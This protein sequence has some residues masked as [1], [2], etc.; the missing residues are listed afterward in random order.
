M[1]NPSRHTGFVAGWLVALG[2]A[3]CSGTPDTVCTSNSAAGATGTDSCTGGAASTGGA[4]ATGGVSATGGLAATGGSSL[5]TGGTESTGGLAST[6]G[7]LATGG[8]EATG[9]LTATG[10][11]EPTGGTPATG[12]AEPTGGTPATGGAEATGGSEATGGT[13]ATGG[14]PGTG[15][16][17]PTGGMPATGGAEPT[18]GM[19]ATGGA[20]TGGDVAT[21]G[22]EA[23]GGSPATG[24][25]AATGGDMG[26]GGSSSIGPFCT[27]GSYAFCEDFEDSNAVGWSRY[28]Q[29]TNAAITTYVVGSE[30]GYDGATTW[31]FQQ[32]ATSFA[33]HHYEVADSFGKGPWTD[34]TVTAWVKP[35]TAVAQDNT[36]FGIC[37]RMS[38]TN[39]TALSGY[40]L[41]LQVDGTTGAGR[42]QL[43][44]KANAA[45]VA[46]MIVSTFAALPG[47]AVGTWYNI[48]IQVVGTTSVTITGYVNGVS[49]ITFTDASPVAASGYPAL[50][51]RQASVSGVVQPP[52][53]ASFD[54]VTLI[55]PAGG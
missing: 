44:K 43:S 53:L 34:Q 51:T 10:G 26:T 24:G 47:F 50:V 1:A 37:A 27:Q 4:N 16:A 41:F 20:A 35:N 13:E 22:S 21:G 32:T 36:K 31:D 9:G 6:G 12:G 11:A 28:D 45:S 2:L 52:A 42:L 7:A 55:V 25:N 39:A 49:Y 18:G 23:T 3:A 17:E 29:T 33:G 8:A 5:G 54:N 30:S 15:G 46:N 19:P 38:G 48:G 40:C 14:A